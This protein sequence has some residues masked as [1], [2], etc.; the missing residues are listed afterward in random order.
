MQVGVGF[1]STNNPRLDGRAA[2]EIAVQQ[3]G[4]PVLTLLLTTDNYDQEDVL[5]A[6]KEVVG[7]SKLVG[8]CVPGIIANL[9]LHERGVCV[10]AISGEGIEVVTHLEKGISHSSYKKGEKAGEA[11]LEKAGESPGTVLVFPDGSAANISGLLRG[12]YNVMGPAF[13]Y[14]GGGSG[15]NLSFEPTY[16]FTDEDISTDALAIA[17][18]K[19]INFRMSL[20]HGWKPVGEPLAVTKAKGRRVYELDGVPALDRYSALIG[21]RDKND[22]EAFSYYSMK[23]PL[24]L[25][26]AGGEFIVRDPLKA[27]GDKSILF[28]TEVPQ[29]T[30]ATIMHAEVDD[31]VGAAE[32]VAQKVLELPVAP[33]VL[34]IFDCVSRYLIMQGAFSREL[35]AIATK[36]KTPVPIIGALS[37]GEI[38]SISG[39][40]LFYNKTIVAAAG[41]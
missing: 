20:G 15:S 25:P 39:I 8:A 21:L 6:V 4:R 19:G 36:I 10:C 24:G 41:W 26:A 18:I 33:K 9:N 31:L 32:E 1:S 14:I 27:E 22:E 40:P 30:I 12:F 23:Y 17:V 34:M 11:L 13:E 28:V 2:S 5:T 29:N 37:F 16:Q 7:E 38:S 3:S 35:K